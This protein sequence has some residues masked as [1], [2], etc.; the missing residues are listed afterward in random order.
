MSDDRRYRVIR[1]AR[2]VDLEARA[3]PAMDVVIDG[4]RID[5]VG[6]PGCEAPA[7]AEII[8]ADDRL[9]IPGLVNAHTHGHGGLAKGAGDR[10]TLE[11]LLN[12]GPWISGS[13]SVEHH[14][15]STLVS[16]LE[17]VK[18][19]CTAC[20]DLTVELP[21]PSVDGM[22]AV[23][24]AYEAVGMRAV[25]APMLADRTFYQSIPGLLDAFPT[26]LRGP[27]ADMKTAE[28]S[29]LMAACREVIDWWPFDRTRLKPALAPTIPLHCSDSLMV[30]SARLAREADIGLHMHLAEAKY[31][32][33]TGGARYARSLTAH[34]DSIGFLG[35]DFTAAHA[36]WLDPDDITRLADHGC[37]IAHNPGSNM[38]LG[39]GLAPAREILDAGV[40]IAIGTDGAQCSDNQNM[41]EAMRFA[42][43]A[44]RV[45]SHD[46]GVW[47]ETSE[48]FR[49]T[50]EGGA[51]ALALDDRMGRIAP[52]F[53]ADI[54]FLDL[55]SINY[56]PLIDPVNQLVHTEDGSAV[57]AVMIDGRVVLWDGKFV[58][59]DIEKVRAE[60]EAAVEVLGS[61]STEA[62][63]LAERLEGH[64]AHFCLGLA[65]REHP[66]H[67]M[68]GPAP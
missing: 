20:Y 45:R 5:E 22:E 52:G 4:N 57:D 44:S 41:F 3:A 58:H 14:Y 64:V 63:A 54:V 37:S 32:A 59:V 16:A 47:L 65:R 25:I 62:R 50:T 40:N 55:G 11:L 10:W 35:P 21:A 29:Q 23:G 1:G 9:L 7:E 46:V 17:M 13:R 36:V 24:R 12:A 66:V 8:Q 28:A 34:L 67:A 56:I 42:S 39:S 43:F 19:G 51:R 31:Q 68:A 15:L 26:D 38:R 30:D 49:A 6:P 2:I 48:V 60:V 33:V 53:L 61:A 18:K 27:A